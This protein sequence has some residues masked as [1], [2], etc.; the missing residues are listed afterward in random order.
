MRF[1][2]FPEGVSGGLKKSQKDFRGF[3]RNVS[4]GFRRHLRSRRRI[5]ERFGGSKVLGGFR[6]ISWGLWK[7]WWSFRGCQGESG[8]L[9]RSLRGAFQCTLEMLQFKRFRNVSG[10]FKRL[11]HLVSG[12]FQRVS[13]TF[14][15]VPGKFQ[16]NTRG[17]SR[18]LRSSGD[19]IGI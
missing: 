11:L 15:R 18:N 17:V 10:G 5:L 13:E 19:L 12:M 1:Q 4:G 16:G 7:I 9:K 6:S 2:R 14:Q 8:A 3:K